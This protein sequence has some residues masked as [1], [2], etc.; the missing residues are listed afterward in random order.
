MTR[1][2]SKY[3]HFL[4]KVIFFQSFELSL[5]DS[6]TS[7]CEKGWIFHFL[8]RILELSFF[9]S[10]PHFCGTKKGQNISGRFHID[11]FIKENFLPKK[12]ILLDLLC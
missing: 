10:M 11:F 2:S 12:N 9:E 1:L 4:W 8:S 6:E 3:L 7:D 5:C